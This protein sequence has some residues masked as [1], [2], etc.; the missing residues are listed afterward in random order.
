MVAR[1]SATQLVTAPRPDLIAAGLP[2]GHDFSV[3]Q[4]RRNDVDGATVMP[5]NSANRS[6]SIPGEG[7]LRSS[8]MH[9]GGMVFLRVTIALLISLVL[10][11]RDPAPRWMLSAIPRLRSLCKRLFVFPSFTFRFIF[12]LFQDAS[13]PPHRGIESLVVFDQFTRIA[14]GSFSKNATE[15]PSW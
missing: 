4:F 3:V 1:A 8:T 12:P 9:S 10:V 13:E 5:S 15:V 2:K 11:G 14:F 7:C 6:A